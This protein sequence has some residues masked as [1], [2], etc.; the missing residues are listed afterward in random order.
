MVS[1]IFAI[2]CL[3]QIQITVPSAVLEAVNCHPV[4]LLPL[5]FFIFFIPCQNTGEC[6][7]CDQKFNSKLLFNNVNLLIVQPALSDHH[8][9]CSVM[10]SSTTTL[11][12]CQL[13]LFFIPCQKMVSSV[14]VVLCLI[15]MY[16]LM[17]HVNIIC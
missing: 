15:E 7:S 10:R 1:A 12:T 4:C 8:P 2:P 3:I 6:N 9:E 16:C 13:L 17:I 5:T 14:F 11:G